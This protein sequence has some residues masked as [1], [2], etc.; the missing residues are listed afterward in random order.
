MNTLV[1]AIKQGFSAAPEATNE[2]KEDKPATS[3]SWMLFV[4][5][6]ALLP[7]VLFGAGAARLSWCYTGAA[8]TGPALRVFWAILAF[9]FSSLY[10]P[11][12]GLLLAPCDGS[13]GQLPVQVGGRRA[14]R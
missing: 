10:Y 3:A 8:G 14:R 13:Q 9:F 11:F 7:L 6:F 12:Y 2:K 4:A 1:Y 5:L